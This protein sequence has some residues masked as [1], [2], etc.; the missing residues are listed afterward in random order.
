ME[1]RR[2]GNSGFKVPA[3]SL[4]TGTFGGG[5][6]F[7]HW[8]KIDA[9]GARR[10]L[11]ISVD[12]GLTM[13]DSS[14]SYSAGRAEEILGQAIA[15]RRDGINLDRLPIGFSFAI[16]GFVPKL[17]GRLNLPVPIDAKPIRLN[18]VSR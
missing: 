14:D 8:G 15:G 1:Y 17:S 6:V 7:E 3:L 12:V 10:L 4:G 5:Q 13:F 18:Q 9:D 16:N 11:D 2:L